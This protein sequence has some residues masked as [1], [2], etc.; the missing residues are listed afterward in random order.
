MRTT[1]QFGKQAAG[2]RQETVPYGKLPAQRSAAEE[3][4]LQELNEY[5]RNGCEICLNGRPSSPERVAYTCVRDG[6]MRDIISDSEQHIREINFIR[7]KERPSTEDNRK[8]RE[9][10]EYRTNKR[11]VHHRS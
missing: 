11:L 10:R 5:W 4:L 8:E 9:N 6:Y 2:K 1:D 7:L 3:A